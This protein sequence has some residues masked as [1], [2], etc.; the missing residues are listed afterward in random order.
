MPKQFIYQLPFSMLGALDLFIVSVHG[1]REESR[2]K[3]TFDELSVETVDLLEAL[4]GPNS[5]PRL[6]G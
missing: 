4:A 1:S 3:G 6:I 2:L 5:E